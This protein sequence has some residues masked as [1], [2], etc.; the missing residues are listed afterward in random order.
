M[1]SLGFCLLLADSLTRLAGPALPRLLLLWGPESHKQQDPSP[2]GECFW[3][4]SL[5]QIAR[6]EEAVSGSRQR[7]E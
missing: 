2:A 6:R 7:Q 3:G 4:G 5:W 1:P